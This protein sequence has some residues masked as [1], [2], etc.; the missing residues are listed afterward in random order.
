MATLP[1]GHE[2]KLRAAGMHTEGF[3]D[4]LKHQLSKLSTEE[5]N[6]LVAI[7]AKLNAGLSDAAKKAADTVGG[8]VW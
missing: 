8:F 7:K 4:D 5:V 1:Q 2:D 3:S 6:S